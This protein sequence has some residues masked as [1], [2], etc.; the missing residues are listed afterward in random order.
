VLNKPE[1]NPILS[2]KKTILLLFFSFFVPN[3]TLLAQGETRPNIVFIL[4][5]DLRYDFL[6]FLD[7]PWIE[8]PNIDRLAERGVYF[9]HA[10]VTT[11][12]CSPSRA[13]ILTGQY[14]H[15]H[16]VL[17]NHTSLPSGT[18]TFPKELQKNGYYTGFVGK[19]HMGGRNDMPRPGFD[20]WVSF[21]GQGKYFDPSLNI[22]GEAVSRAGYTP[23]ILADYAVDFLKERKHADQPWFLYL[24]HKS[25]HENFSPAPRHAGHYR[26]L[27]VPL[28]DSYA[29]TDENYRGKPN[30]LRRYRH[31]LHGADRDYSVSNYG[32]FNRFFQ[33]YSECML[34]VDESVGKVV[35]TLEDMQQ[36]E[37]TI[38]LFF[39]D[40]GYLM[41]EHGLIDKRVMHEPSIRVPCF[42]YAPSLDTEPR[43]DSRFVLNI[44][45]GPTILDLAGIDV[46][47]SMHGRSF[48]PLI[49]DEEVNWRK[50]FVYEYFI[51]A[52]IVPTPTIFGLRTKKYSYMTYQGIWDLHELYDME[53]DPD[54][55]HN[56]LG[57]IKTGHRHGT[58]VEITKTQQPDLYPIV[59]DLDR[60][61]EAELKRTGG[62]RRPEFRE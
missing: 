46:P 15:T 25:I 45:I 51:E 4:I 14:V 34:G 38:I 32:S 48:L 36:L 24:S 22:N 23:D 31:S 53:K 55:R 60:R 54:Q 28:P 10:F 29:D 7:H 35:K 37:K 27:L 44:D 12:L 11:S 59:E 58:V 19:W 3:Q 52:R 39:S 20:H 17:D 49:R 5:D 61:L 30:W 21:K 26:D 16:G 9:D 56:L 62:S 50:E 1:S 18:P 57:S 43:R 2:R 40:N 33:L 8:T 41:G 6:S 13:S 47:N 42:V